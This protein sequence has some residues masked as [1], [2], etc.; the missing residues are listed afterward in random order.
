M[1]RFK[2]IKRRQMN[3]I[4]SI[5]IIMESYDIVDMEQFT[6]RIHN[7]YMIVDGHT[8]PVTTLFRQT[9]HVYKINHYGFTRKFGQYGYRYTRGVSY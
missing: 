3:V 6:I 5:L 4:I 8:R 1:Y 2:H 7:L 9:S